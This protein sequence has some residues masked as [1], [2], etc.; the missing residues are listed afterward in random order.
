MADIGA[1]IKN[2][3][4]SHELT[5]EEL[6]NRADLTKGFISMVERDLQSP[7]LDTL[8]NILTALDSSLADFFKEAQSPTVVFTPENRIISEDENGIIKEIL[9]PAAQGREADM[10]LVT[11]PANSSMEP[12]DPHY[13]DECG[14]VVSGKV[15]IHISKEVHK[16]VRGDTF[17]YTADRRHWI[18]NKSNTPAKIFW[19][20]A[21]PSF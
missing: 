5:Q 4:L 15:C 3:R 16:A 13:G 12:E 7:S 21:P 9:I 6:A 19:I 20:S 2:M 1:K 11:L 14:I 17:Y 8:E 18:E 10:L